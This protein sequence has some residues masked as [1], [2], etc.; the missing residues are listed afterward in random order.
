[1]GSSK[2]ACLGWHPDNIPCGF[3]S[4]MTLGFMLSF[5]LDAV[6]GVPAFCPL[7]GWESV[8]VGWWGEGGDGGGEL[9]AGPAGGHGGSA[10]LPVLDSVADHEDRIWSY[11]V[12]WK[13]TW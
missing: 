3:D 2:L 10:L 5:F 9:W 1:M 8:V 7:S 4:H 6:W 12:K 13:Q 11:S